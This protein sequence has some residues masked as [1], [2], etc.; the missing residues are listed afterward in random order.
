GVPMSQIYPYL[1]LQMLLGK[2]LGVKGSV[3]RLL[4][5][6]DPKTLELHRVVE[7]LARE[8][9]ERSWLEA[10]AVYRFFEARSDGDDLI[11]Y[12]GRQEAARFRFPRQRAGERLCL[13]GYV[14]DVAAGEP[15]Y[16]AMF[17]GTWGTGVVQRGG[18]WT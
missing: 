13:S 7:E 12:Q 18:S 14:P 2:H 4:A 11:V 1:N 5:D 10:N 6:G 17:A 16:V 8:A 9:A 3:Q 15:E